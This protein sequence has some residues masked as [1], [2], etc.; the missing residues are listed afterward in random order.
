MPPGRAPQGKLVSNFLSLILAHAVSKA[1]T[2]VALYLL[3]R[4]LG[5]ATFGRYAIALAFPMALEAVGDLGLGTVIVRGG[6]GRPDMVRRD[7]LAAVPAKIVLAIVTV[8]GSYALALAL[9]LSG[10]MVETTVWLAVAKA[11]ESLTGLANAV[12][13]AFEHMEYEA[14]SLVAGGGVR[15]AFTVY[16]LVNGFGLL[17]LVK[18]LA[19]S[20][21]VVMAGTI[22]V[23][24]RRFIGANGLLAPS[25]PRAAVLVGAGAPFAL[26]SFFEVIALRVDTIA[27]GRL[28]G[29][30]EAGLFAAATRLVEP[31]VVLPTV[32][33]AALLPVASR[34][35]FEERGT[36]PSL[37]R[38]SQ[39][40]AVTFAAAIVL[41]LVGLAPQ[42]VVLL[43]GEGFAEAAPAVRLLAVA[44]L[45]LFIRP[46]LARFLLA[47]HR[48]ARL[49][50]SQGSGLLVNLLV[51]LVLI[52]QHGPNGAAVAV[53]AGE[54][55]TVALSLVFLHGLEDL[56]V[57]DVLPALVPIVPGA[58]VLAVGL[59]LDHFVGTALGVLALFLG[60]RT[61]RVF[62][63][64]EVRYLQEA[65]PVL[66][67]MSRFLLAPLGPR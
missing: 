42:L 20:A 30:A 62:D 52:P 55:V 56:I 8:A 13:E 47:L 1:T 4:Y 36:L 48:P 49:V 6:A 54:L 28:A 53:I 40:L 29:D 10:E 23:A 58:L 33:G 37:F 66:G 35:L 26:V 61:L 39:K 63:E 16:A 31:F 51:A 11:F 67:G 9:G 25:L 18:A 17:G 59:L 5:E 14:A 60:V 15:L 64:V 38:G 3:T 12:F 27:V 44:L 65:M 24:I 43:F 41:V 7:V 46:A 45:P 50:L 19:L 21:A 57:V 32:M 34:H 2:L 22:V